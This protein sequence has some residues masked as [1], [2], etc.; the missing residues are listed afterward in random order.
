MSQVYE[1]QNVVLSQY[2]RNAQLKALTTRPAGPLIGFGAVHLSHD[3][4]FNPQPNSPLSYFT[5]QEMLFSGYVAQV[6]VPVV[7][8]NLDN[9]TQGL[10]WTVVFEATT[11]TPFVPDTATGYWWDDGT[12]FTTAERFANNLQIAIQ[13]ANDYIQIDGIY[14]LASPQA[15]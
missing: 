15:A 10:I 14:P 1:S 5:S 9:V 3:P 4:A 8:V 11:A 2:I 13:A 6:P 12:Q 7:P